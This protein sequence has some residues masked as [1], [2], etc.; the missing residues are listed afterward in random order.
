MNINV[1]SSWVCQFCSQSTRHGESIRESSLFVWGF[2]I[3]KYCINMAIHSFIRFQPF[4]NFNDF[5]PS[6]SS[7]ALEKTISEKQ[8]P[9]HC[10]CPAIIHDRGVERCVPLAEYVL[11]PL[12]QHSR[13]ILHDSPACAKWR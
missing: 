1:S 4:S 12:C 2:R 5:F 8:R 6:Q 10:R 11:L 3:S 13:G 9:P 7:L